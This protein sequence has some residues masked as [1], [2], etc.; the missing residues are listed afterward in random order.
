MILLLLL[1]DVITGT[2]DEDEIMA[3]FFP[4]IT[5]SLVYSVAITAIAWHHSNE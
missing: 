1:R 4:G 3:A 5:E 2:D